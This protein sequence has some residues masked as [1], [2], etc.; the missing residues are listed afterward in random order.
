MSH[1][2]RDT[3]TSLPKELLHFCQKWARLNYS[4]NTEGWS[5]T[6]HL[7]AKYVNQ[8]PPPPS[9][10]LPMIIGFFPL[11]LHPLR[12]FIHSFVIQ[13]AFV[14][15]SN[16]RQILVEPLL[17]CYTVEY[18]KKKEKQL[19]VIRH[20]ESEPCWGIKIFAFIHDIINFELFVWNLIFLSYELEKIWLK[21][22]Y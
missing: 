7:F 20:A 1:R 18:L 4:H 9:G 19:Y 10:K 3:E 13:Q 2:E 5:S 21:P 22:L 17:M 12:L 16:L 8:G 6:H 11:P 14:H 15:P